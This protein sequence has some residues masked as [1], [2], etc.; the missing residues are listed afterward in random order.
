MSNAFQHFCNKSGIARRHTVH[1]RPQQNGNAERAN[2]TL[3]EGVTTLLAESGL[4]N[5]FWGKAIATLV[6]INVIILASTLSQCLSCPIK[7]LGGCY[8]PYLVPE[9]KSKWYIY[10]IIIAVYTVAR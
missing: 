8:G 5:C 6:V 9:C 4:P 2:R 3:G 10:I 1:N 7:D